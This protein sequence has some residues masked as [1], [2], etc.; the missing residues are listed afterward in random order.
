MQWVNQYYREFLSEQ[1]LL[2]PLLLQETHQALDAL[3]D[4]LHLGSLYD[5]Q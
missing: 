3:T 1:D 5:F 4:I 2:D